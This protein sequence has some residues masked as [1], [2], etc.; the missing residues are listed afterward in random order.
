MRANEFRLKGKQFGDPYLL[1]VVP[2]FGVVAGGAALKIWMPPVWVGAFCLGLLLLLSLWIPVTVTAEEVQFWS[3]WRYRR[4]AIDNILPTFG[5]P[6][7]SNGGQ[8]RALLVLIDLE[9]GKGF[10]IASVMMETRAS[11]LA[12]AVAPLAD[13]MDKSTA[14]I[15]PWIFLEAGLGGP[16]PYS[17]SIGGHL[18]ANQTFSTAIVRRYF[19][20]RVEHSDWIVCSVKPV[21]HPNHRM[22]LAELTGSTPKRKSIA[23]LVA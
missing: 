14:S 12:N 6:L 20:Y 5:T 3:V 7:M 21:K 4:I 15:L 23:A 10:R 18:V 11:L 1:R 17:M 2:S 13:A 8:S 22:V 9:S 19:G 16:P